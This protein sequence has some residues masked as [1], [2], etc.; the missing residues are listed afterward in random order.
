[1]ANLVSVLITETTWFDFM[2]KNKLMMLVSG[3]VGLIIV[4]YG[5]YVVS[6]TVN[7]EPE[8]PESKV[9]VEL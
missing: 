2:Y 7:L 9:Q 1:M 6:T 3:V 5:L 4:A 8:D